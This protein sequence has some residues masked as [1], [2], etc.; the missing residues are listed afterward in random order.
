MTDRRS[1][2]KYSSL[3]VGGLFVSSRWAGAA[4]LNRGRY[5]YKA[6]LQ[7]Y[8]VRDAMDKDPRGSL[9]RV[10]K[11]G[12]QN[13]EHA[14][15]SNTGKFYGMSASEFAGVLGQH[16]LNMP[17]GHYA[18]GSASAKGTILGGWEQA[19]A[20]AK[21]VGLQYMVCAYLPEEQ[22]KTIDD[23]KRVSEA[24]NK[25]GEQC[26][27]AGIQFCYHNHNFEFPKIGNQV[28]YEV[29]LKNTDSDLV[30]MEMDIYWITRAGYDPVAMFNEHRGRFILWHVKDMD[31]TPEHAFTEVG[32]GVIDWNRVFAH[33]GDSGMRQFFV[34]ED[35]C[36]GD[37]FVSI[38]KSYGYLKQHIIA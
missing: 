19:V 20:D 33:A 2:L 6:G 9:A 14:T 7:L 37:P 34:E 28:P 17:S 23:Y 36:P 18:L 35:R 24:F 11:I 12:Y 15:Y 30:K 16:H 3:M 5:P 13:V 1:F 8:T 32:S 4:T 38:A 26:R 29:L 22:R 27:K 10:A 21:R 31:N 25:A